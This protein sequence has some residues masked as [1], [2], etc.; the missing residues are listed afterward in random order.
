[1]KID[2]IDLQFYRPNPRWSTIRSNIMEEK[3]GQDANS[4]VNEIVIKRRPQH[5]VVTTLVPIVMMLFLNPFVFVLPVESGERISYTVT[6]F[7]SQVVF[8][9]NSWTKYAELG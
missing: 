6:I 8:Y 5:F 2:R 7:L 4:I 3:I 1:M 9:D